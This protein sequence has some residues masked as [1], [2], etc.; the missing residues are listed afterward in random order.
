MDDAC[1]WA[2]A[3]VWT[4]TIDSKEFGAEMMRAGYIKNFD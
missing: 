3:S 1:A 2:M 4:N